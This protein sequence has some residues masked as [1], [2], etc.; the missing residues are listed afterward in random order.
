MKFVLIGGAA[1]VVITMAVLIAA[2]AIMVC[3][4]ASVFMEHY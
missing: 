1:A 2:H 4:T 3:R